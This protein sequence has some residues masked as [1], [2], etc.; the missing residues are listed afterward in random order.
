MSVSGGAGGGAIE[1][2]NYIHTPQLSRAF[3]LLDLE[4]NYSNNCNG[5]FRHCNLTYNS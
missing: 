5:N 2:H 3:E 4:F 1:L